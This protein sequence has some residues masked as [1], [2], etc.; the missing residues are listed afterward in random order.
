MT[1][2]LASDRDRYGV[3]TVYDVDRTTL[4]RQYRITRDELLAVKAGGAPPGCTEDE[5]RGAKGDSIGR[6]SVV[7]YGIDVGE[8]EVRPDGNL[9]LKHAEQFTNG[10]HAFGC[11]VLNAGEW[12]GVP[13]RITVSTAKIASGAQGTLP[14]P[15]SIVDGALTA[16]TAGGT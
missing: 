13:P 4:L 15:D 5:W 11:V 12:S 6:A 9:L 8:M 1:L 16:S 10:R 3:V 2:T 7:G 14:A